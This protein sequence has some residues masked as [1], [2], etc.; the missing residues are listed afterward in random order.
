MNK[1]LEFNKIVVGASVILAFLITIYAVVRDYLGFDISNII[2]L[3]G[4]VWVEVTGVTS[5]Y[6]WKTKTLNKIKMINGLDEKLKEQV[7]INQILQ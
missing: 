4:I 5:M 6:S 3:V 7:D 2:T 1:K